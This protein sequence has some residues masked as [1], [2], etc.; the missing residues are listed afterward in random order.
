MKNLDDIIDDVRFREE[1]ISYGIIISV[2][3]MM[4]EKNNFR[5]KLLYYV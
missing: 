2:K 5:G 3:V 1:F 4:D